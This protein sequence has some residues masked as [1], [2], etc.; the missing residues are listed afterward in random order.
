[1]I[2]GDML[3]PKIS[4]NTSVWTIEPDGN[5]VDQFLRSIRRFLD[6]PN[7]TL[8]LP[9]HGLPF[10]G[11]AQ[12]VAALEAHHADRLSDLR[13][14]IQ[15]APQSAADVLP[16]LFRRPLDTHQLYFAMGESIAHL[17]LL[18]HAQTARRTLDAD[19][20]YRFSIP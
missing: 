11:I 17:N 15:N 14:A 5:P 19:G 8:V 2:A 10:R 3:L 12:R 20:V 6:L 9:A 7:D 4:T 13:V 16:V 1:M 18:M